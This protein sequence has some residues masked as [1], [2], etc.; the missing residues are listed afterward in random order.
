MMKAIQ[1]AIKKP[2]IE[3]F[4]LT[5]RNAKM[6]HYVILGFI[7]FTFLT[8]GREAAG[9][10]STYNTGGYTLKVFKRNVVKDI[11]LSGHVYEVDEKKPVVLG[12]VKW[13]C[14]GARVDTVS[15]F[16][17]LR[18]GGPISSKVFL[19]CGTIGYR[20]V[21]TEHFFVEPGDSIRIDFFLAYDERPFIQCY[22]TS[23]DL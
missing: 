7:F 23:S 5:L 3:A 21:E 17:E 18:D 12:Y 2:R 22:P 13:A 8:C 11:V 16:Y 15:G 10:K 14:Q 4:L 1:E 6:K 19:T 9:L 20:E